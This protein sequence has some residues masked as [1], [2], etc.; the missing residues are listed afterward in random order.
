MGIQKVTEAPKQI[1][2]KINMS[3]S[4]Y[5]VENQQQKDHEN[6]T[7]ISVHFHIHLQSYE[8]V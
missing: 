4:L 5:S 3:N 1:C 6:F 8:Q 7:S 2:S